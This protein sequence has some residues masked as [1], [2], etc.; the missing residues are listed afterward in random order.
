MSTIAR[1][2]IGIVGA[3]PAEPGST[4]VQCFGELTRMVTEYVFDLPRETIVI[5][6]GARGIDSIA[7]RVARSLGMEV[8]EHLPNPDLVKRNAA[9]AMKARNQLIVDDAD[10]LAAFVAPWSR[11]TWDTIRRAQAKGIVVTIFNAWEGGRTA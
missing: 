1:P 10:E 11:G 3:R 8:I 7:A 4:G 9:A 2:R 5:S 6:G